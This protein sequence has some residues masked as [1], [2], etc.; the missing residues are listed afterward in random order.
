[1]LLLI[2][3]ASVNLLMKNAILT[4]K[5]SFQLVL[6]NIEIKNMFFCLYT[7]VVFFFFFFVFVL[8]TTP[9]EASLSML[10]I[11]VFVA[12]EVGLAVNRSQTYSAQHH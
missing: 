8:S 9:Y 10:T 3:Y 6:L 4:E 11:W 2:P 1:M 12:G 5:K 7:P